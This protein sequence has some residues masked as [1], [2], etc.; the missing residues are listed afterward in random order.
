MSS[1]A[2]PTGPVQSAA[3]GSAAVS[4]NKK[5]HR[6]RKKKGNKGNANTNAS[7][8]PNT[9]TNTPDTTSTPDANTAEASVSTAAATAPTTT[10]D[11][12]DTAPPDSQQ[13]PPAPEPSTDTREESDGVESAAGKEVLEELESHGLNTQDSLPESGSAPDSS[14]PQQNPQEENKETTTP[15]APPAPP[16]ATETKPEDDSKR[17]ANGHAGANGHTPSGTIPGAGSTKLEE[18]MSQDDDALRLEVEQLR[19]QLERIQESHTEEVAQ[20]RTEVE[21]AETAKEQ[22]EEQYQNLLGRVEKI[23][24]T[25]GDRLK[26]DKAELE[27]TK[28]RLEELEAQN[29]ELQSTVTA[30][31]EEAERLRGEVQEQGRELASLRSRSNLSQQ[32][33]LKE[34]DDVSRQMQHLKSELE[35]TTAAMGEWEVIAMEERSLRESL[36]D[37]VSDLEEQVTTSREAF[38]RA[39]SDREAQSQA[40]DRLQRALQELQDTR[41]RELREM[42]ES[43][44]EQVQALKKRTQEADERAGEAESARE[45][46]SKELERTVP[47]EKEVKEKNLLIGKL[48]H[49]AIVLND[50]LTKALKYI[51]KTKPEETIDKQLVTNHFLQFL[52]LDRSDP[53]KF[54]ILQVMANLLSWTDEQREKAGLARPGGAGPLGSGVGGSGNTLRLPSS[55]FHRTPSSPALSTEFFEAGGGAGSMGGNGAVGHPR[56]SLADLWASF[57]EQSVDEAAGGGNGGGN[58]GRKGSTASVSTAGGGR[59]DTRGHT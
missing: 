22:A 51:K 15:P 21:E 47:F 41:K 46:L 27:E 14:E 13:N 56:E 25:L 9:N 18:T 59:P 42:V 31:E 1:S 11:D 3:N 33:W 43:T 38:E 39:D 49:E 54:Q 10:T 58:G 28:D 45:K 2:A 16:A 57:L 4:T 36:A 30:R 23:R 8:D 5:N 12:D 50:H 6:N 29:E 17:A 55:P 53:K 52:T 34:K 24:E 19:K 37:K 48:R 44:E 32:N 35:S 26:R 20:L 7:A 40:V